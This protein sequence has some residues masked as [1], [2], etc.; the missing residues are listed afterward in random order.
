MNYPVRVQS[1]EMGATQRISQGHCLPGGGDA[2]TGTGGI[3]QTPAKK[4]VIV[5]QG[6]KSL[7][8]LRAVRVFQCPIFG[9]AGLESYS[10]SM[11][12]ALIVQGWGVG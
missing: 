6:L 4:I 12:T 2:Q 9:Q 7:G 5:Y 8:K 3:S 11:L 1:V 10:P